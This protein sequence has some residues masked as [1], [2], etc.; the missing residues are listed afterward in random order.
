MVSHG[1]RTNCLQSCHYFSAF[2]AFRAVSFQNR[3][4]SEQRPLH[5]FLSKLFSVFS[6]FS[7]VRQ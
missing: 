7:V 6:V 1:W 3:F 4:V 5:P 2:P